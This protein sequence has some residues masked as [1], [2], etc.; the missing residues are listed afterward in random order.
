MMT[1]NEWRENYNDLTSDQQVAY[2]NY[3]ETQYPNQAHFD[4]QF[5]I[6]VFQLVK[7]N[8]VTEAGGW[9]GDLANEM[10]SR[11]S[12]DK[13]KNIEIC[14][15]AIDNTKCKNDKFINFKPENFNWFNS[16]KIEGLFLATHFI[17][18][19]SN[20]HFNELANA[21][22]KN[23]YIYFEAPLTDE[24][25]NWV[26]YFGTHKLFYGWNDIKKQF[27]KHEIILENKIC[28]LFKLK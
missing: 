8:I 24:G 1:F 16:V 18:H 3:L 19:L 7:P 4:L 27:P 20:E 14:Q 21:L 2:Y 25:E 22:Q 12:I 17:E 26:D 28:K 9:K 10:F 15:N 13:W 23:E 11:F 5:A 6:D